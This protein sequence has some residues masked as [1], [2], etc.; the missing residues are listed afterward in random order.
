MSP[1]APG[2]LLGYALQFPRALVHLL[3]GGPED[4]VCVEVM[5]DVA[6]EKPLTIECSRRMTTRPSRNVE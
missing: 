2:P 1:N 4:V 3:R 6:N 5:G